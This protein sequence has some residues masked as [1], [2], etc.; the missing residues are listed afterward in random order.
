MS[1][2]SEEGVLSELADLS[3]MSK[4]TDLHLRQGRPPV[5]RLSRRCV[6]MP[7]ASEWAEVCRGAWG[8]LWDMFGGGSDGGMACLDAGV[9]RIRSSCYLANGS[10]NIALRF[11]P[12]DVP[13]Y[14]DLGF[15][16]GSHQLFADETPGLTLISGGPCA[17]K[18]TTMA[19]IVRHLAGT[20]RY[21][22]RTLESPIEYLQEEGR[23]MVTQQHVGVEVPDYYTGVERA[24]TQDVNVISIGEIKDLA[25]LRAAI[26]AA[27]LNMMVY[28]TIHAPDAPSTIARV[29]QEFPEA[30]RGQAAWALRNCIKLIMAQR[31]VPDDAGIRVDPGGGRL[32]KIKLTYQAISFRDAENRPRFS[33]LILENNMREFHEMF[34]RRNLPEGLYQDADWVLRH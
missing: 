7:S 16:S 29:I 33:Q 15:P 5:L 27:N 25:S 20:G 22:I 21:H 23:S 30:D 2:M 8:M 10:Q 14:I 19:A 12:A 11:L 13:D 17:G 3:A 28:A 1:M 32:P 34:T 6:E 4:P 24:L 9:V 18:S 31:L 26:K